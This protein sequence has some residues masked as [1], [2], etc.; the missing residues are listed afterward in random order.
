MSPHDFV[1]FQHDANLHH[2]QLLDAGSSLEWNF[3]FFNL[4]DPA[5]LSPAALRSQ[6]WF[7]ALGFRQAVS[8]AVDR[9]SMVRLVYQ[10]KATP[11]WGPITPG[12]KLWMD[13]A[14]PQPPRSLDRARQLLRDAK[15]SWAA[16]GDLLDP[17]HQP[18]RFTI[19]VASSNLER[20]SLATMIQ[21][22]L[23]QIGMRVRIVP[24]EFRTLLNRILDTHDYEACI[25]GLGSGDTDPNADSNV[26]LSDGETHLWNLHR[27]KPASDW[28][29]EIDD[30]MR[31]QLT[32]PSV[33][34]RKVEFNRVQELLSANQPLIFLVSPHVLVGV[35]NNLGNFRPAVMDPADLWNV[36]ELYWKP[37]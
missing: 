37:N 7:S 6:K 20:T 34:K 9:Q 23:R 31:K 25:L 24:L 35:K 1:S 17:E 12:N 36:E 13:P 26:W 29:A 32:E 5:K 28:E 16:N 21:E 8:A 4:N 3:L 30:L 18:V 22:D 19:V 10:G 14:L 2:V 15:F 33:D 27:S 11:I